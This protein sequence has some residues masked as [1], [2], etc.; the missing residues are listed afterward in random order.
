MPSDVTGLDPETGQGDQAVVH[1]T[2][3]AQAVEIEIDLETGRVEIIKGVGAFDV[4]KAI[5]PDMVRAQMEGG[6]RTGCQFGAVRAAPAEGEVSRK[7]RTWWITEL[8]P[9]PI[10]H[11]KCSRSLSRCR[12]MTD[13]GAHVASASTPWCQRFQRSP[14]RSTMPSGSVLRGLHIR[15]RRCSWQCWTPES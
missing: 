8:P 4:G 3:G 11:A 15:R 10:S 12:R 9:P 6:L 14:T 7:T 1:Y 13:R 2:T 5:N